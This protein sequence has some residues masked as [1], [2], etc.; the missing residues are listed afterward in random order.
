[1]RLFRECM[2]QCT[3]RIFQDCRLWT[4]IIWLSLKKVVFECEAESSVDTTCNQAT[5]LLDA[6]CTDSCAYWSCSHMHFILWKTSEAANWNIHRFLMVDAF[7]DISSDII[8][9]RF[10]TKSGSLLNWCKFFVWHKNL[11]NQWR[12]HICLSLS[13]VS[14]IFSGL[15]WNPVTLLAC[16]RK[17]I[18]WV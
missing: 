15:C 13:T 11:S 7:P 5:P 1:M 14:K 3:S 12:R 16:P 8:I 4:I 17:F 10:V 18:E 9:V 2:L 6:C